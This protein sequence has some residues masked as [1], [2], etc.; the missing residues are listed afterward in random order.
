MTVFSS[1]YIAVFG[2]VLARVSGLMVAAP[3]FGARQVPAQSKIGLAVMVSL[4][5]TPLQTGRIEALPTGTAAFGLL[6]GRELL[7]GLAVG[8]AVSLIFT[9]IQVGS[10]LLGVQIGFGFGGLINPSSGADSSALDGFF[11]VLATVIFLAANG[12]HAVLVA[13]GRTF[14]LAPVA[15]STLPA[16]NPLQVM[17]L[18]QSVFVVALRIAMP[19]L[20]ALLLTDVAMGLIGRAAPQMQIMVIGAPVKI[21][22]G[23]I[24][25]AVSTPTTAMLMDAAYRNSG[26]SVTRLLGG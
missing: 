12:H 18:I 19:T 20:G 10:Q 13:L 25:L 4:V 15:G 26:A 23:L 7:I 17:A 14:E 5:F 11:N 21:V 1:T 22:V 6:V 24:F 9:G 8:F 3:V 2:L 16:V